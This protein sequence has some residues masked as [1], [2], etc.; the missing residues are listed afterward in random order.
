MLLGCFYWRFLLLLLWLVRLQ[1]RPR[2]WFRFEL[3]H[4]DRSK[5]N[6]MFA[7]SWGSLLEESIEGFDVGEGVMRI[8]AG[9]EDKM[10]GWE[11][12]EKPKNVSNWEG[13]DQRKRIQRRSVP[14]SCLRLLP[15]LDPEVGT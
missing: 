10:I 4:T 14:F 1:V 8:G 3:G 2:C 9:L 7:W 11:E 15:S 12:G 5:G 6:D 13:A